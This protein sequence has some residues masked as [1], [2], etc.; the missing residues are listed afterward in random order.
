M[1]EEYY[2]NTQVVINRPIDDVW[3]FCTAPINWRL[4]N[5][6]G[7]QYNISGPNGPN[8]V[9]PVSQTMKVGDIFV[10]HATSEPRRFGFKTTGFNKKF[11]AEIEA[12]YTLMSIANG[13]KTRWC[14]DRVSTVPEGKSLSTEFLVK[15]NHLE[16]AYQ[17]Q[18][19]MFLESQ[20]G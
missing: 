16:E 15:S 19:K 2:S 1:A 18:V 13:T 3:N 5:V 7:P 8:D 6:A 11:E 17:Q 10:E 4:V 14:R 9:G 12:V 20:S